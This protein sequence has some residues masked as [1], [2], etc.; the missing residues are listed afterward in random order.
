MPIGK[1]AIAEDVL[2]R[3]GVNPASLG[4]LGAVGPIPGGPGSVV[5][6]PPAVET[7]RGGALPVVPTG[8]FGTPPPLRQG[9]TPRRLATIPGAQGPAAEEGAR[10]E[11]LEAPGRPIPRRLPLG[12]AQ[13]E[14]P[15]GGGGA[16][17][18]D[19]IPS[20]GRGFG[21][22]SGAYDP[23]APAGIGRAFGIA[24]GLV[25]DP[26]YPGGVR[27]LP[28]GR[29]AAAEDFAFRMRLSGRTPELTDA[30]VEEIARIGRGEPSPG[31]G[32]PGAAGAAGGFLP[33]ELTQAQ[34]FR[35]PAFRAAWNAAREAS[36]SRFQAARREL[37][38]R[39]ERTG[40]TVGGGQHLAALNHLTALE[41]KQLSQDILDA[42]AKAHVGQ[43]TTFSQGV[44]TEADV[45]RIGREQGATLG[46]LASLIL[47]QKRGE[48]VMAR[49]IAAVRGSAKTF[50][51]LGE[52]SAKR[53][54]EG[55][56]KEQIRMEEETALRAIKAQ[57]DAGVQLRKQF[58]IGE[59]EA[60][61]LTRSAIRGLKSLG[62]KMF[63]GKSDAGIA[64][65]ARKVQERFILQKRYQMLAA[66]ERGVQGQTDRQLGAYDRVEA[67]LMDSIGKMQA[68]FNDMQR[69]HPEW[70][71][72]NNLQFKRTKDEIGT[73]QTQLS[74]V[75]DK[76]NAFMATVAQGVGTQVADYLDQFQRGI[77]GKGEEP[78]FGSDQLEFI[79]SIDNFGA[80]LEAARKAADEE[81]KQ[82]EQQERLRG[83]AAGEAAKRALEAAPAEEHDVR[84]AF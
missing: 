69:T 59:E 3:L 49:D 14:V 68:I 37:S 17:P 78:I 9:R 60:K 56:Q 10:G 67:G 40:G 5:P 74:D 4:G 46:S 6:I 71:E 38:R 34:L 22:P 31:F 11:R 42:A 27:R 53:I 25:F 28:A 18:G 62:F 21:I 30:D 66:A 16:G 41:S 2:R 80:F 19:L 82:A 8:T 54:R 75:R 70:N 24:P 50:L 52:E 29:E 44:N 13:G 39:V 43:E 32:Q 51:A 45:Q 35:D 26:N 20:F 81:R 48:R 72:R 84:G 76:R 57:T 58:G 15:I 1:T 64:E 77:V 79:R 55:Q 23:N 65:R 33:G 83:A 61:G 47:Q 7:S 73:M 36:A 12:E 63:G